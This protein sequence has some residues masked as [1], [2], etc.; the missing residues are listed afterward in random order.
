MTQALIPT[1][2]TLVGV[3]ALPQAMVITSFLNLSKTPSQSGK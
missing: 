2:K 1:Q 3:V